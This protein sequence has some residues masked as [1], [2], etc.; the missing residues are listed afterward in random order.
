[1]SYKNDRSEPVPLL[2]PCQECR[3]SRPLNRRTLLK[4]VLGA[5]VSLHLTGLVTH[6]A[7]DPKKMRPQVGDLLVFSLGD[8]Q[9]QVITPQDIPVGGPP[10]IA[11]AMEPGTQ[12]VR[13]GSR[14]NRVLLVHLTPADFTEATRPATADGIVGYSAVC[15]HT[16]C[17]VVGWQS[18]TKELLCPCHA[19]A[20]DSKDRAR[21]RGGPAPRALPL[22]PLQ[23]AD[24]KLIVAGP[25]SGRVGADQK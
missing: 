16:G 1:M 21:V 13:D 3:T 4:S 9:G 17:D 20:F 7:D 11:Y 2:D 6:A 25:F 5:G 24:G 10:I 14:L 8:R 22:L 18:N 19:S 12:T 23:L 15:T